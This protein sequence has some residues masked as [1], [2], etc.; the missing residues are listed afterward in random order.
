MA[1]VFN[2]MKDLYNMQREAKKM[3]DKMKL[4]KVTGE[5][6]KGQVRLY[7]NG[8]Q[9]LENLTIEEELLNPEMNS[10]LVEAFK[11]AYKDFQKKLQKQMMKDIDLGS[12]RNMLGS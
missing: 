8:A 1:N 4:I 12:I 2:Q 11:E 5:S 3:K 9:E 10:V 7:F 6:R